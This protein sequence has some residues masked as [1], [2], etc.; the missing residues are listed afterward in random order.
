MIEH[1]TIKFGPAVSQ[2]EL[3]KVLHGEGVAG[4]LA[5]Q[6]RLQKVKARVEIIGD[7]EDLKKVKE[8]LE[9]LASRKASE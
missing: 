5:I 9:S 7:F 1:Y 2:K 4:Q 6:G 3:E 8:V